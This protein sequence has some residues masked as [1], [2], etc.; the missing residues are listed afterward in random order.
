MLKAKQTTYKHSE[1]KAQYKEVAILSIPIILYHFIEMLFP[2][3]NTNFAA[4]IGKTEL[5]SL[6]IANSAFI[7]LMGFGWGIISIIGINTSEMIGK[8]LQ[9]RIGINLKAAIP[10]IIILGLILMSILYNIEHVWRYCKQDTEVVKIATLYNKGI[11]WGIIPDLLKYAIFQYCINLGFT[12]VI[13]ITHIIYLPI[14]FFINNFFIWEY[15][16]QGLGMLGL[17]LGTAITYWL[18]FFSIFIYIFLQKKIRASLQF[19]YSFAEYQ[20][21]IKRQIKEGVPIGLMFM[22]EILFFSVIALFLGAISQDALAAFQI[23]GQWIHLFI[24]A[25]YGFAEVIAILV[26]RSFATNDTQKI[27]TYYKICLKFSLIT[28]IIGA[29]LFV[30]LPENLIAFDINIYDLKNKAVVQLAKQFFAFNAIILCLDCMRIILTSALRG[31]NFASY[32]LKIGTVSFWVL[33]LPICYILT[34][35]LKLGA[36]GVFIGMILIM[37]INIFFAKAKFLQVVR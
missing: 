31:M 20:E 23:C 4:K 27:K 8:N 12:R 5:A 28:S 35:I 19:K 32:A 25:T 22:L 30:F 9:H 33:G 29:L 7:T 21:T 18:M 6:A 11:M 37:L 17:G 14:L 15:K 34:F 3:F 1:L 16:G 24:I 2:F 13:L 26:S 10:N 36:I